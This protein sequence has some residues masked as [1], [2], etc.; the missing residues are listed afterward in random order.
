M[1]QYYYDTI[2]YDAIGNALNLNSILELR[3]EGRQL[4]E[5]Y[6]VED[7]YSY[8]Y[9]YNDEGVRISK[10]VDGVLH[11]YVVDGTQIQREVIYYSNS[12]TPQYDMR[13]FYDAEG[14]PTSFIRYSFNTSGSL[15][16]TEKFYYGTNLQ[17][18]IVAIYNSSGSRIYTYEYDAWG[19]VIRS[20]STGSAA[21]TVGYYNPFR[22]RGYYY[23]TESGLYYLNSRYY[24]P[25]WG[26]FINADHAD[27][28]AA[29][30]MDLTDK[31]LFAYCDNN[32][33]TRKDDGGAF[34]DTVFDVISLGTSIV[35]V[36]INPTDL[37]AW[38]GLAGDTIDLV[39]FVT[40]VGEVT[41]AAKTIDK[42][43]DT[44]QIAKAVDFTEEAADI[45]KTLDRSSGFTKSIAKDGVK[46]H[47]GYKA[48][49]GFNPDFKEVKLIKGIRPDYIDFDNK[50]IYELKP[51][52]PRGVRS[53]IR[54]LQKYNKAYG[55][56]FTLRL[57]LY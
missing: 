39:P 1:T 36:C 30:P 42:V 8:T 54:Q 46:I 9:A 47:R 4:K 51:M 44:V 21:N 53:G 19:N 3:W 57:E 49:K 24:N 11:E 26:R 6:D 56:G 45:V 33:V 43:A 23:D 16:A 27:V 48:T 18:D 14:N 37:W 13:Y 2:S 22:Y 55:G 34:W 25:N 10:D 50:I 40:G 20:T 32:P 7:H 17:G 31:N 52:N 29:T 15:T 12:S 38:A 28:I 41:R 35:E 5:I